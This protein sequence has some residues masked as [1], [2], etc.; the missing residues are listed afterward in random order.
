MASTSSEVR[1]IM[2]AQPQPAVVDGGGRDTAVMQRG[3]LDQQISVVKA[4][5]KSISSPP[6]GYESLPTETV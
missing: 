4:T 2:I 6:P 5:D 1:I 3:Q